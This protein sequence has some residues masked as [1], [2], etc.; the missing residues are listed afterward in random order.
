MN[1]LCW[2]WIN[3]FC[4]QETA[5]SVN[6]SDSSALCRSCSYRISFQ[7]I[8]PPSIFYLFRQIMNRFVRV[9]RAIPIPL[10]VFLFSSPSQMWLGRDFSKY[11]GFY[12]WIYCI[13]E[14]RI[15]FMRFIPYLVRLFQ[16]SSIYIAVPEWAQTLLLLFESDFFITVFPV[17]QIFFIRSLGIKFFSQTSFDKSAYRRPVLIQGKCDLILT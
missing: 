3:T 8:Q 7:V 1:F 5:L 2:S 11:A 17:F 9:Y 14:N 10:S 15:I 12:C 4:H 16:D 6:Q 13:K